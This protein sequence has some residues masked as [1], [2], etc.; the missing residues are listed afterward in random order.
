MVVLEEQRMEQEQRLKH[1]VLVK[2]Q[3][4][5][6]DLL[7]I[8]PSQGADAGDVKLWHF[9]NAWVSI[10]NC[11]VVPN[12]K[13]K[14][15]PRART[16]IGERGSEV[17]ESS[18]AGEQLHE[19]N[20]RTATSSR[21]GILSSVFGRRQLTTR[22]A[23]Q[24]K[25]C[26]HNRDATATATPL[27]SLCSPVHRPCAMEPSALRQSASFRMAS[28][29]SPSPFPFKGS[30][31]FEFQIGELLPQCHSFDLC[32]HFSHQLSHHNLPSC[33]SLQ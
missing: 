14:R 33:Q 7:A 15:K 1:T 27:L 24:T 19:W 17:L 4:G 32:L 21:T 29:C 13:N 12:V 10:I 31:G 8:T 16:R 23:K 5:A 28:V 11:L 26:T 9:L 22:L 18:V 25:D 20:A 2:D 6:M 30:E 3:V